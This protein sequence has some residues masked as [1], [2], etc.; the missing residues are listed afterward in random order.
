VT[1]VLDEPKHNSRRKVVL[2][3][4]VLA[5]I[6]HQRERVGDSGSWIWTNTQHDPWQ[7]SARQKWWE[8]QV[9]GVSLQTLTGVT[10]YEAT[11]HFWASWAVNEG[12]LSPY[13]ASVLMGHSD[14]G[15]L[16]TR[17]YAR[18]D[19]E[20]ALDEMRRAQRRAA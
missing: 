17:V 19:E 20:L 18:K 15:A 10:M 4:D 5:E 7:D 3:L 16:L 8:K 2:P 14:G 12:G 6:R 11:R 1:Q 9:G 13:R